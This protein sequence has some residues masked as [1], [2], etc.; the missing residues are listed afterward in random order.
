VAVEA[1]LPF[2]QGVTYPED[3]APAERMSPFDRG[4]ACEISFTAHR[5]TLS[6]SAFESLKEPR[7]D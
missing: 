6:V 4:D 5:A 7:R 1:P 3:G 2:I